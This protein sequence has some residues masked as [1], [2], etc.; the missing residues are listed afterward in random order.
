MMLWPASTKTSSQSPW[1]IGK[2]FAWNNFL[3]ARHYSPKVMRLVAITLG[4]MKKNLSWCFDLTFSSGPAG[5]DASAI[6]FYKALKV[7]PAPAELVMVYQKTIPP[8]VFTL[9]MGMLSMDVSI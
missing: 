9:V 8:E 6:C 7:Y 2:S 4:F 5:Y 1:K 3:L